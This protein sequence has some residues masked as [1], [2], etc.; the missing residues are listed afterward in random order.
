L[1]NLRID[2]PVLASIQRLTAKAESIVFAPRP[3]DFIVDVPLRGQWLDPPHNGE[4][5]STRPV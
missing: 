3:W 1:T 2:Q 5:L 4:A